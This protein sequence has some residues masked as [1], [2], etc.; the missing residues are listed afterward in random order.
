MDSSSLF[1]IGGLLNMNSISEN[2]MK[3]FLEENKNDF[4][5]LAIEHIKKIENHQE[6]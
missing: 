3:T 2:L 4:D 6:I 5:K 1:G